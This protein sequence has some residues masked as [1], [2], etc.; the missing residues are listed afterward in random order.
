[1]S[2]EMGL[3]A[4][5]IAGYGLDHPHDPSDLFRCVDYCRYASIATP[6]LR[7]RMAGRSIAWDRLLP[8]WDNLTALLDHEMRTRTDGMAPRTYVEM[9]RVIHAGTACAAC[10][11]TGRGAECP[12]CKGSGRRSGGR[13]RAP[14]CHFGATFCTDC[15]GRGYTTDKETNG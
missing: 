12:K 6:D 5:A 8:E 1:M 9:K 4:R 10:D 3:S 14:G 13:C 11:A 15:R 2:V 7:Q